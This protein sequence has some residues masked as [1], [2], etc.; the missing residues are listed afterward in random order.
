MKLLLVFLILSAIA[1][2]ET[3]EYS[4]EAFVEGKS[5]YREKHTVELS[6]GKVIKST[7]VYTNGLGEIIARLENDYRKS[8]SVPEHE[9]K[10]LVHGGAHGVRYEN[11]VIILFNREGTKE[12]T[13]SIRVDDFKNKLLVGGQGFHYYLVEHLEEIIKKQELA[14]KF[15]IPGRLDAYDFYLKVGKVTADTVDFEIEIDNWFLKLFA[16]KLEL[17]YDRKSKRLLHYSGLSNIK[18]KKKELMKVK[19][20]YTYPN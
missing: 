20:K 7:T 19:I 2:A 3:Q 4:G 16:P 1:N 10:D 6:A 13:K 15:L 17:V 8:L 11:N 9:M 18:D 5:V 14:L 12:D